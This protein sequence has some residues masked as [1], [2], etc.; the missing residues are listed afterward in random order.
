M[1]RR[2]E[3]WRIARLR[4]CEVAGSAWEHGE[5]LLYILVGG[6]ALF[7]MHCTGTG[8]GPGGGNSR[9]GIQEWER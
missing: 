7:V 3:F 1:D 8:P 9:E 5:V 6:S 2:V 4:D